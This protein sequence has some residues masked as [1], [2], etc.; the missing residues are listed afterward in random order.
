VAIN[1]PVPAVVAARV[2][3]IA[4]RSRVRLVEQS[5]TFR[6]IPDASPG[7]RG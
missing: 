5:S 6:V 4:R 2:G 1:P 3:S 7:D